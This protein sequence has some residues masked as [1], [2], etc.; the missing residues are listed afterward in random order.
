MV[1]TSRKRLLSI[2]FAAV[3]ALT[4]GLAP[5]TASFATTSPTV[6]AAE[7]LVDLVRGADTVVLASVSDKQAR[8]E[9]KRIVTEYRVAVQRTLKGN[10]ASTHTIV[11]PGGEV[12]EPFP[13]AM[14]IE[15]VPDLQPGS[16]VVLFLKHN[17]DGTAFI[18]ALSQGAIIVKSEEKPRA[19]FVVRG[20]HRV[21]LDVFLHD[22]DEAVRT[23]V[24][25][26]RR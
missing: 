1:R 11:E 2:P 24:T 23:S 4:A 15:G 14:R 7:S 18:Y 3:I 8:W 6:S 10:D 22:V 21:Q 13:V 25:H 20:G 17:A 16:D 26:E 12:Q 9:G 19:H 5:P